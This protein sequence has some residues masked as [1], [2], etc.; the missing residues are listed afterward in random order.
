MGQEPIFRKIQTVLRIATN[1]EFTLLFLVFSPVA[2]IL[3]QLLKDLPKALHL[4]IFFKM[5]PFR[6][7][8]NPQ[9]GFTSSQLLL[10]NPSA[11]VSVA[12]VSEERGRDWI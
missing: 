8:I 4:P 5:L 9:I 10:S 12:T 6:R 3:V 1:I 7:E 11:G 2:K